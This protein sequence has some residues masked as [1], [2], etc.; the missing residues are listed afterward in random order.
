MKKITNILIASLLILAA[1][2]GCNDAANPP[3]ASNNP[4]AVNEDNDAPNSQNADISATVSYNEYEMDLIS[5]RAAKNN[6][7]LKIVEKY[8]GSVKSEDIVLDISPDNKFLLVYEP[9]SIKR[10]M[11]SLIPAPLGHIPFPG[12]ISMINI[13]NGYK[14]QL[15]DSTFVTSLQWDKNGKKALIV[16][17]SGIYIID[18]DKASMSRVKAETNRN[19]KVQRATWSHDGRFIHIDTEMH[20]NVA[21]FDLV[22]GENVSDIFQNPDHIYY[23]SSF[24][25]DLYIVSQWNQYTESLVRL[26]NVTSGQPMKDSIAGI[27]MDHWGSRILVKQ[28]VGYEDRLFLWDT[29]TLESKLLYEGPRV[30][31]VKMNTSNGNVYFTTQS[32]SKYFLHAVKAPAY[33]DREEFQVPSPHFWMEPGGMTLSFCP[34]SDKQYFKMS[35]GDFKVHTNIN[36]SLS[37]DYTSICGILMEACK[38][39]W[40]ATNTPEWKEKIHELFI[41]TYDPIPQEAL[42]NILSELDLR[43]KLSE[44]EIWKYN[45]WRTEVGIESFIINGDRASVILDSYF[46]NAHELIKKDGRWYITGFSTWPGTQERSQMAKLVNGYLDSIRKGN[47]EKALSYWNGNEDFNTRNRLV[48]EELLD[49]RDKIKLEVGEIEFWATSDPHRV[50]RNSYSNDAWSKIIITEGDKIYKYKLFITRSQGTEWKIKSWSTDKG[51]N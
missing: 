17:A 19:G 14:K 41:N 23:K 29:E 49:K 8:A 42:E 38:L 33:H 45:R 5:K 30:L 12:R 26:Y 28:V 2:T 15:G 44:Y 7:A 47:R 32:D 40:N 9:G 18:T 20:G 3:H 13:S 39:Y 25:D 27:Y 21:S 24:K 51:V 48:V 11:S 31:Q 43:G 37:N 46:Y 6:E 36:S 50:G 22:K 1:L 10:D 4:P 16:S 34:L 35:T